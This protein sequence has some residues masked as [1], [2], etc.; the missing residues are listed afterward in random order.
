MLWPT[1]S[2][3]FR[4]LQALQPQALRFLN[5]VDP[6][7]ASTAHYYFSTCG[8]LMKQ[9]EEHIKWGGLRLVEW[10]LLST[11][12]H[13]LCSVL[14]SF[15]LSAPIVQ[16]MYWPQCP[17]LDLMAKQCRRLQ[18]WPLWYI[19]KYL[20]T[21]WH[22]K[23]WLRCTRIVGNFWGIQFSQFLQFLQFSRLIGK[24]Q[25]LNAR[26]KVLVCNWKGAWPSWFACCSPVCCCWTS[27]GM[28]VTLF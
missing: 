1:G 17:L 12:N 2:T 10:L 7:L 14:D 15:T 20:E 23:V 8:L 13:W 27:T 22:S 28:S 21:N 25:K 5:H 3:Q 24:P 11:T 6:S 4:N 26:N 19:H 9:S 16:A 18:S